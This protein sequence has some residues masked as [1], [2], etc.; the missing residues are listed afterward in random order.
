M[1]NS[2]PRKQD[3]KPPFKTYDRSSLKI[4]GKSVPGQKERE[5]EEIAPESKVQMF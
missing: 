5:A 2:H 4:V 1:Q 3:H